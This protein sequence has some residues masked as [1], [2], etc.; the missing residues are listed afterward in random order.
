MK[1]LKRI[2]I[3]AIAALLIFAAESCHRGYGCPTD[4]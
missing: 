4:L 2:A 1:N 3:F